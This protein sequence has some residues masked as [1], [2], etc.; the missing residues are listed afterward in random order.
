MLWFK[1]FAFLTVFVMLGIGFCHSI[2]ANHSEVLEAICATENKEAYIS[3]CN[4]GKVYLRE[5]NL[6]I[7]NRRMYLCLGNRGLWPVSPVILDSQ[8]YYIEEGRTIDVLN[9]CKWC[10]REYFITCKNPD[11]PNPYRK[12]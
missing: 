11:C 5:E 2:T 10:G 6:M 8:G 12:K 1:S 4:G 7:I 3:H 9:T